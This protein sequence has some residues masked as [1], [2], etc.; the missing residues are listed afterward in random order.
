[1]AFF[2]SAHFYILYSAT[3]DRYYVG[4]TTEP[5]E[6]RIRKH[7]SDHKGFTGKYRDWKIVYSEIHE[8]K[9]AA[10]RRELEVKSWKSRKRV[11]QLIAGSEHPD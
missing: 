11:A 3:A 8:S 10:Y 2:M 1:M 5:L 7:N 4:H 9:N 6:E